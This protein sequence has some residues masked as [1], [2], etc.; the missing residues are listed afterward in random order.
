MT[1]CCRDEH[2]CN[3]YN[4]MMEKLFQLWDIE[5]L[6][7]IVVHANSSFR[8]PG[9]RKYNLILTDSYK[10]FLEIDIVSNTHHSDSN[11]YYFIFLQ[12]RDHLLHNEMQQIFD[13]CWSHY[14]INCIVQVQTASGEVLIYTYFPFTAKHCYK[15]E[16]ILFNQ[17]NGTGFIA[18]ELFPRKLNNFY[19]CKLKAAVWN[20]APFVTLRTNRRGQTR[21]KGGFEGAMVNTIAEK[22]NFSIEI[23]IPPK[24][25]QRGYMINGTYNGAIGM[26]HRRAV[27]FSFGCFRQSHERSTYAS[28]TVPYHQEQIIAIAYKAAYQFNSLE[29]LIHPFTTYA[30]L[31]VL[32][33]TIL[34][35]I[36][37]YIDNMVLLKYPNEIEDKLPS[38]LRVLESMLGVSISR[39]PKNSVRR[40]FILQWFL[41]MFVIRSSYQAILFHLIRT[42]QTK[43]LPKTIDDLLSQNY[44]VI[45]NQ[46]TY[47]IVKD[48]T[49]ASRFVPEVPPT[50]TNAL[51]IIQDTTRGPSVAVTSITFFADFIYKQ[52]KAG[53]YIIIPEQFVVFYITMYLSK[54]SYLLDEFNDQISWIR[55]AGLPGAWLS[56][57]TDFN[58]Y[59]AGQIIQDQ[60]FGM[61]ELSAAFLIICLGSIFS[62]DYYSL[63]FNINVEIKKLTT[64][65]S[66]FDLDGFPNLSA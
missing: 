13:Y 46:Q 6:E 23:V 1:L 15:I 2:T 65:P 18:P 21:I 4:D 12:A 33:I 41:V 40:F 50:G 8:V 14:L 10:A 63:N 39:L 22:L 64:E 60:L 62:N 17:F 26:L 24:N 28:P 36:L 20:I 38:F 58:Y 30:W 52:Q 27:D 44:N 43:P 16:P 59:S 66:F 61:D 29:L 48:I 49:F 35:L 57:E 37:Q 9:D 31:M 11:E 19:G 3:F 53:F 55:G 56:W 54:H 25:E 7:L 47:G 42:Q 5:I 51:L 32:V 34:A 45:M